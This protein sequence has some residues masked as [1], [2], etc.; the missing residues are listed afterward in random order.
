M[1]L[2]TPPHM[3]IDDDTATEGS[4]GDASDLDDGPEE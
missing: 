2:Q 4:D 1:L 3:D